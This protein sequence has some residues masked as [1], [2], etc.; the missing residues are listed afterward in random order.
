MSEDCGCRRVVDREQRVFPIRIVKVHL[1]IGEQQGGGGDGI[2]GPDLGNSTGGE[3]GEK[4]QDQPED[5]WVSPYDAPLSPHDGPPAS[6][7]TTDRSLPA[8]NPSRM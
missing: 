7:N 4:C 2:D 3:T 8:G 5:R 1:E 6:A